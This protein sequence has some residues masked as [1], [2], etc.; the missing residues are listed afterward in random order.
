MTETQ[1]AA[2]ERESSALKGNVGWLGIVFFVVAAAAPLTVVF[3]SLPP[4][5]SFGGVGVP[6]AMLAAGV[7]LILFAVGGVIPLSKVIRRRRRARRLANGD[8]SLILDVKALHGEWF[9][10]GKS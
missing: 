2:S 3:G 7:V 5:I 4:A 9:G 10:G 6:G 1:Q 8:I